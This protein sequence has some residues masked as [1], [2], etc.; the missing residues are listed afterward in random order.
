M[1]VLKKGKD[2]NIGRELTCSNCAAL[3]LVLPKDVKSYQSTDYTGG[4]DT[5]H[6]VT[7]PDCSKR[8]YVSYK[9]QYLPSRGSPFC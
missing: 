5:E 1:K 3:L 6:Y 8:I 9:Y 2:R 4:T 7:C